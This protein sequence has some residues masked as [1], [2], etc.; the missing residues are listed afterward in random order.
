MKSSN[1]YAASSSPLC[2]ERKTPA[3][4]LAGEFEL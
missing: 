4:Q 1:G 2:A 3:L